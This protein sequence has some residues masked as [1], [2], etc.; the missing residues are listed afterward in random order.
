MSLGCPMTI[1]WGGCRESWK[2][3]QEL[4]ISRLP[5][6]LFC[7]ILLKLTNI[8]ACGSFGPVPGRPL[9]VR[10]VREAGGSK[11]QMEEMT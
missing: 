11:N 5:S 1:S 6:G 10:G 3:K 7:A 9:V 8:H 2:N 4:A